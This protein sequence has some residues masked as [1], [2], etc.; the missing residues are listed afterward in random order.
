DEL[1]SRI[2]GWSL[3]F[4]NDP[5]RELTVPGLIHWRRVGGS[6]LLTIADADHATQTALSRLGAASMVPIDVPFDDA[7]MAY[8]SRSRCS[9]S[10]LT[11]GEG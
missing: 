7:V 8:L 2:T 6:C 11:A 5:P 9:E 1:T 10:F 3:T 4:P